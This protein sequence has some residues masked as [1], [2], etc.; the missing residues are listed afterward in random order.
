VA[1]AVKHGRAKHVT[2][3]LSASGARIVFAAS[4]DGTGIDPE[5]HGEGMGL[6]IMRYRTRMLG[7]LLDIQRRKTGGTRLRCIMPRTS[8]S[9]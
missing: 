5:R 2:L 9:S 8:I 1:N 3:R 7:G 4:D 6:Q